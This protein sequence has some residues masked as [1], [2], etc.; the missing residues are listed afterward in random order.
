M[1]NNSYPVLDSGLAFF[2]HAGVSPLPSDVAQALHDYAD[3]AA[4]AG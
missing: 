4:R 2:N 3:Q 1:N